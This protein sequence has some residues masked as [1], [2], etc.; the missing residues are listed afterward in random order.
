MPKHRSESVP[1]KDADC[2][3]RTHS[4]AEPADKPRGAQTWCILPNFLPSVSQFLPREEASSSAP[5]V[6][7]LDTVPRNFGGE[8]SDW[9]LSARV[10][11]VRETMAS[12]HGRVRVCRPFIRDG[13][14]RPVRV[15]ARPF[16]RSPGR[17]VARNF[18]VPIAERFSWKCGAHMRDTWNGSFHARQK[19]RIRELLSPASNFTT[20]ASVSAGSPGEGEEGS[21]ID[22]PSL[23]NDGFPWV[24]ETFLRVNETFPTISD[25]IEGF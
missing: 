4:S 2:P 10:W 24:N 15:V 1:K 8:T 17:H 14:S 6:R 21:A 5:R 7:H 3:L 19:T 16:S 23:E 20:P 13:L 12:G 25:E 22:S 9:F 11:P 18:S